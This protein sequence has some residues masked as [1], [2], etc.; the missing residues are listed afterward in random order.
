MSTHEL[1]P[2]QGF[3]CIVSIDDCLASLGDEDA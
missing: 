2:G 1:V 3:A